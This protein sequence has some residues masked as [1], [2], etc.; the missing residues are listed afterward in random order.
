MAVHYGHMVTP[1]REEGRQYFGGK[2]GQVGGEVELF[3]V[4]GGGGG[5]LSCLGWGG[6]ASPAPLDETLGAFMESLNLPG[7]KPD[8]ITHMVAHVIRSVVPLIVITLQL[9]VQL[10]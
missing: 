9:L 4:G 3:G 6:G 5:E 7:Y 2:L 8:L 10:H 1:R